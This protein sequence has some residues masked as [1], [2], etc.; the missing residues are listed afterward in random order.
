MGRDING[1]APEGERAVYTQTSGKRAP[2]IGAIT[3]NYMLRMRHDGTEAK[4]H[5]L[6]ADDPSADVSAQF[7][8]KAMLLKEH[9][10]ENTFSD[11]E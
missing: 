1:P 4:L 2:I 5:D 7:P 3:K 6:H 11:L 10:D 9:W 8:E